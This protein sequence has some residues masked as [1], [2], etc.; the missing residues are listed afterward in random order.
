MK[1][2][3]NTINYT[4]KNSDQFLGIDEAIIQNIHSH[5]HP[6]IN[7]CRDVSNEQKTC[8]GLAQEF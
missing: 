2:I 3:I 8:A 5:F 4:L 1:V 6:D 7:Y